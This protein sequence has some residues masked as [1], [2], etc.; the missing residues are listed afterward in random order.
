MAAEFPLR[1]ESRWL[2]QAALLVFVIT[3]SIGIFNGFHLIQLSRA[4]LLTHV[5]AGTIG[6]ITLGVMAASLWLFSEGAPAIPSRQSVTW[7]SWLAAVSVPL[8]VLAFLS[9]N[10]TLRAIFGVPVLVAI[11][12]FLAWLVSQARRV[13]LTIPRVG[14]MA[15]IATLVIGSCIGVL[16]QFMLATSSQFLDVGGA[17]GGHVTAQLVGY[18]I[19]I[20]MSLGEW[21][22]APRSSGLSRAGL[23]QIALLFAG[24]LLVSWGA[25]TNFQP[26]LGIFVPLEIA[27]VVIYTVRLGP[28][29]V[30]I[31]WLEAGSRRQFGIVVP[32]LVAN[33]A[34][35][36]WL[37]VGVVTKVYARFELIPVW[38]IFA[39][40]H[41]MFVGVMSNSLFGLIHELT[42]DRRQVWPWA[43]HVLFW[44]MNFGMVGFVLTLATDQQ[45]LEKLFTPIMGGSILIGILTYTLR[46][47]TRPSGLAAPRP[48]VTPAG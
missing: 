36:I 42:L 9:G 5:H 39:F 18:L 2:F 23:V 44:G 11:V 34:L 12:G 27:A 45:A 30:R 6:W 13:P 41:T 28:N 43:E 25:L 14:V 29:L 21:R 31:R 24:G 19:L 35:F 3:V 46:L 33:I 47:Q 26:L 40:E 10:Y 37:I 1:R 48:L 8:Y 32:F 22:L 7:L 38:L 16:V 15:A 17:I 20:G 4:V